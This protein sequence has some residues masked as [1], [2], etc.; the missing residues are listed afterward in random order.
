MINETPLEEKRVRDARRCVI[1]SASSFIH[2]H[3]N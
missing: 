3:T 1:G 2:R